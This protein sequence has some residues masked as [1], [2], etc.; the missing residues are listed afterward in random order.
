MEEKTLVLIKPD[1]VCK[2]LIGE[3]IR[4]IEREGFRIV[5][6]KMVRPD[7]KTVERFYEPH[8]GKPFFPGL[9]EFMLTAPCVALVA[10][11]KDVIRK[12][13][14]LIGER[15]PAEAKKGTVR[16]DFGSDGRR[17]IVHGSDSSSSAER[18]IKCFFSAEEIFSYREEDWLRSEPG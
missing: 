14:E 12:V 1:G 13:R 5:A 3:V 16:G 4:R 9:V 18:E 6:L 10:E 8:K 11:G 2:R 17:N 7:R 15:I